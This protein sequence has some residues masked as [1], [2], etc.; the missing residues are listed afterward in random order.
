[1]IMIKICGWFWSESRLVLYGAEA[2]DTMV[3][4]VND[5]KLMRGERVSTLI[6]VPNGL[7]IGQRQV[8]NNLYVSR[9]DTPFQLTTGNYRYR[10]PISPT[11][12]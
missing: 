7:P 5:E 12:T 3:T 8:V 2:G 6:K 1:M 10:S 4:T 11:N 9:T